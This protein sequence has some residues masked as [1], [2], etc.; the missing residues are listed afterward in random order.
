MILYEIRHIHI[1][2]YG[3]YIELEKKIYAWNWH[4][5]K[6]EILSKEFGSPEGWFLRVSVQKTVSQVFR[7]QLGAKF[8][9]LTCPTGSLPCRNFGSEKL[10]IYQPK[11]RIVCPFTF[12]VHF[13]CPNTC[14]KSFPK[15]LNPMKLKWELRRYLLFHIKLT[16]CML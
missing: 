7:A 4:F 15:S 11:R 8:F 13:T 10:E 2:C 6:V 1:Q 3:N 12:Q 9:C 16:N 14:P 5:R